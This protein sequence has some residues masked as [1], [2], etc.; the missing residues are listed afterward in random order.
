[1][2]SWIIFGFLHSA[3]ATHGPKEKAKSI[4]QRHYKF[5][6]LNYSALSALILIY[7]VYYNFSINTI[8]LWQPP[9]AEKFVAGI[10]GVA[11]LSV[12]F[13]CIRQYFFDL[14][15]ISVFF[16]KE[17]ASVDHLQ[18]NGL[19]KYVRHPLYSGTLLFV[20]SFFL[21]Q[22]LLSN[23]ISCLCIWFY[24]LIGIHFEER[25]L[26]KTFGDAYKNY[27]AKAPMLIPK[28]M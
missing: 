10:A 24:T 27:A 1:M 9:I 3:L 4:M 20:L 18:V 11:G 17:K 16:K 14:S 26:L 19:N 25:K 28:L 21:W 13:I 8:L 15:G 23:L 22:P 2:G 5:Y 12:M 7:I 6:R